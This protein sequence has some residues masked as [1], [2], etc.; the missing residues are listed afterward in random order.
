VESLN[1]IILPRMPTNIVYNLPASKQRER[2]KLH[3]PPREHLPVRRIWNNTNEERSMKNHHPLWRMPMRRCNFGAKLLVIFLLMLITQACSFSYELRDQSHRPRET[4][5]SLRKSPVDPLRLTLQTTRISHR[6]YTQTGIHAQQGPD[7]ESWF[8]RI[9]QFARFRRKS[10]VETGK[11]VSKKI[12]QV[13]LAILG[14]LLVVSAPMAAHASAV[15]DT[16]PAIAVSPAASTVGAAVAAVATRPVSVMVELKLTL[17]LVY[18]ALMGA[19]LGKERSLARHSAGVRT[20][21]LVAMGASAF[22]ICSAFGFLNFPGRYDPSRM[23]AN[24]ASGVGFVGAGVITTTSTQH[25]QQQ[26]SKGGSSKPASSVVH[27]LTTAATI[28]LSA[29]VGVACGVGL[30]AVATTTAATTILILRLGRIRPK[31]RPASKKEPTLTQEHDHKLPESASK[32]H[33]LEE[34]EHDH[35]DD[36]HYAETHDTSVWD[37]HPNHE[38]QEEGEQR[39]SSS[40]EDLGYLESLSPVNQASFSKSIRKPHT[41]R[42]SRR[43]LY[44]L[45]NRV[46]PMARLIKNGYG[47]SNSTSDGILFSF[48]E[49]QGLYFEM[50]E[51]YVRRR[52]RFS[53]SSSV[54]SEQQLPDRRKKDRYG[55]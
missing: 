15:A 36:E 44:P 34:E 12:L 37:E 11:M 28:W 31:I 45:E 47:G 35:H 9:Y 51:Q 53:P 4:F 20:M 43:Q 48:E 22:T 8:Q 18:A 41:S 23:A 14:V 52:R 21:A 7:L 16:T 30:Y 50:L 17:R 55:P 27:G 5:R 32:H 39:E 33:I 13:S 19:T 46:D 10:V 29:A 1:S 40:K 2:V 49:M 38:D 3:H 25:Q 24:V 26:K 42:K 54:R 6:L